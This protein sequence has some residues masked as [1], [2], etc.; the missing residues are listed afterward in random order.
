MFDFNTLQQTDGIWH[1]PMLKPTT[2]PHAFRHVV[3]RAEWAISR[4]RKTAVIQAGGN[5]GLW[6]RRYARDFEQVYTFEPE[7]LTFECLRR[8]T[9]H[10]ANV[11]CSQYALGSGPGVCGIVRKSLGS[12]HV[13]VGSDRKIG[14]VDQANFPDVGLIQLDIEGY[15]LP[16]LLGA[17]NTINRY[18]PIIQLEMNDFGARFPWGLDDVRRLMT[19]WGYKMIHKIKAD[20]I[21]AHA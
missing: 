1:L 19:A 17:Q 4:A 18:K 8:N 11:H 9:E 20:E 7:P 21:F 3:E 14:A 16:A 15:E 12:H 5:I 2:V 6:P 13:V 10:L